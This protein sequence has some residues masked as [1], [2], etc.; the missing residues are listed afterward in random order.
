MFCALL[1]QWY[2]GLFRLPALR[3]TKNKTNKKLS[4][5]SPFIVQVKCSERNWWKKWL[6]PSR[7]ILCFTISFVSD[8]QFLL[9]LSYLWLNCILMLLWLCSFLNLHMHAFSKNGTPLQLGEARW[10]LKPLAQIPP[11]AQH[12]PWQGRGIRQCAGSPGKRFTA[13]TRGLKAAFFITSGFCRGL[14]ISRREPA[15]SK[16]QERSG[17]PAGA[18]LNQHSPSPQH[19]LKSFISLTSQ[20][21]D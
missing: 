13:K 11:E 19:L 18:T 3:K 16:P 15:W 10:E 14:V 20:P 8:T 2:T 17:I 12:S 21:T 7:S 4:K 5:G 9:L 6:S 1:T